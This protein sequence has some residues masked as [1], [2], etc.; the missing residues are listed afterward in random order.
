LGKF[1]FLRI[2]YKADPDLVKLL[3]SNIIGTPGESMLYAQTDVAEKL[4]KLDDPLFANLFLKNK[5][6]GTVCFLKRNVLNNGLNQE[7]FYVRY[8]TFLDKFRSA[9]TIERKGKKSTIREEII[10]FINGEGLDVH[11]IPALF[12]YVDQENVRSRRLIEEFGFRKAG[13]FRTIP[14]TRFF[15][16][17]HKSVRRIGGDEWHGIQQLIPEYYRDYSMITFDNLKNLNNYFVLER[18]SVPVCGVQAIPDSWH[19]LSLP[20]LSGKLMMDIIPKIPILRRLFHHDYRF[21]FLEYTFCQPGYEK[22]LATLFESVLGYYKRNSAILCLDPTSRLYT[23]VHQVSLGFAH[24][25]M[26]EKEIEIV[27]ISS[28]AQLPKPPFYV[29]GPDVL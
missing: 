14:F 17:I 26:G 16:K 7:F 4:A 5:L 15:P 24:R 18:D 29:S 3:E 2:S 19:I 21:V 10:R 25:I 11:G 22:H 20:G 1:Q 23:Q 8:F 27:V 28:N 9:G 6:V 13:T 12:A